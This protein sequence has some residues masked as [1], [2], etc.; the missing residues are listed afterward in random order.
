[1]YYIL[2]IY[3]EYYYIRL[4]LERRRVVYSAADSCAARIIDEIKEEKKWVREE[5]R[6]KKK[7]TPGPHALG[8]S[9]FGLVDVRFF[10]IFRHCFC[11]MWKTASARGTSDCPPS[12]CTRAYTT[13]MIMIMIIITA[14]TR[15][16]RVKDCRA[17]VSII[18]I[19]EYKLLMA[20]KRFSIVFFPLFGRFQC[21][22][23]ILYRWIFFFFKH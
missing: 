3:I 1:M 23:F 22:Q 14:S 19:V 12:V 18:I 17:S 6:G 10:G 8:G 4:V 11:S 13:T 16:G 20:F 7:P 2:Y 9:S 15:Y 5:H 21:V